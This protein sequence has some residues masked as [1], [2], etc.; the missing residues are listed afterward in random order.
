LELHRERPRRARHYEN[1][2]TVT[3][4]ATDDASNTAPVTANESDCYLGLTGPCPRTPGFWSHWT[5][6]WNGTPGV[7]KQAGQDDFPV[8]D[9][10]YAVDSNHNGSIGAGDVA[11]LLIGDTNHNGL[12]D[13]GEDTLFISLPNALA[14]IN[15]SSKQMSDGVVKVG[16]DLVATW[17]N[18]LMGSP[19]GA[20]GDPNSPAHFI[21]AAVNYL[22]TFGDT[23]SSNTYVAGETFDTYNPAH[24]AVK[25]STASW[26]S[27][28]V[29]DSGAQIHSALDGYNNTGTVNGI[30][31]AADC[32]NPQFLTNFHAYALDGALF[33]A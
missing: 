31:Y 32:D 12:T 3:G 5:D 11:G 29:G 27:N 33:A 7:P 28:I 15:A 17:L 26:N 1:V 8:K 21:N 16:R 30:V 24:A 10:L 9:L 25:T 14:L 4:T 2:A 6:F 23:S 13:S 19:I 18:S 20:P 22:Q